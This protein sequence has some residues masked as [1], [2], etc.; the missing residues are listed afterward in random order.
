MNYHCM[1]KR[2]IYVYY[3]PLTK[4][5]LMHK[6]LFIYLFIYLY[7]Y[8]IFLKTISTFL[9]CCIIWNLSLCFD[10]NPFTCMIILWRSQSSYSKSSGSRP[11]TTSTIGEASNRSSCRSQMPTCGPKI[12]I[13]V[14]RTS[15]HLL[16]SWRERYRLSQPR[17][18]LF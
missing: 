3:K 9:R 8:I 6:R 18:M 4:N 13:R 11:T 14:C 16:E 1:K 5:L 17:I 7:N 15:Q 2:I 12:A 10:D